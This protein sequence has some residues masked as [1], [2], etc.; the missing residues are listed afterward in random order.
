MPIGE[1][2][3]IGTGVNTPKGYA[4]RAIKHLG[5]VTGLQLSLARDLIEATQG[6]VM[7]SGALKLRSLAVKLSKICSDLR[8]AAV[9]LV[10]G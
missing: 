1:R 6:F 5:E 3:A 9:Q 10:G 4:D 8:Q 2:A 7:F